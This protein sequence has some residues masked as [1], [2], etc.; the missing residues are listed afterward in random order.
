MKKRFKRS[1]LISSSILLLIQLSASQDIYTIRG[2]VT[3]A[4]NNDYLAAANIRLLGTSKGTITNVQ[5]RYSLSIGA[6]THTL[7]FSYLA[8]QPETLAINLTESVVKD[9]QLKPSPIQLPEF[10]VLAED[11]AIEIIRKAIANKRSWMDKLKS[12]KFDAFSR[13]VIRR[14]TAIASITESYS[15]GYMLI[16]DTLREV[17]KQKRQTE[18]IPGTENFAAV[19]R[20]INFND[21]EIKLFNVGVN[22]KST[23]FTFVGPTAPDALDYYDYKLMG[24]SVVNGFE[25]YKIRMIPKSRL[26]PL[27]DGIITIAEGTYAVMG[28]DVKPNETFTFPFVKDIDLRY[29][30]QFGLFDSLFWMPIDNRISGGLSVSIVGITMPR[31]GIEATSSIYDYKINITIPDTVLKKPRL[32]VDSSSIKFDSTFWAQNEVLPLTADEQK[33]YK[34]LDSTQTLDKQFKPSGP[35]MALSDD[36]VG[37]ILNYLDVRFN[38]VEGFFFGGRY[39]MDTVTN[40]LSL[41]GSGGYGF[42]DKRF[43]YEV[44]T[45][46]F[47]SKDRKLKAGGSYY[48][49]LDNVP[50][51][52]YFGSFAITLM[53]LIDKNDYRDYFLT[54]GWNA[55]IEYEPRR[56]LS[57]TISFLNEK[58]SSMI[59]SVTR[60]LF[61]SQ[62]SFRLNP[63]IAEGN[64]RSLQFDFRFGDSPAPLDLVPRDAI[65]LRIEH[66]SS[67]LLK[68]DFNFTRYRVDVDFN[69]PTYAQS[70]LFPPSLKFRVSGGISNGTLPQQRLFVL[71]SRASG[72]APFGVLRGSGI[73]EFRG[74]RF[75]KFNI[76]HNFRSTPFLA[77]DI[78]YFYRN[79]IEIILHGSFAQTWLANATTS[80]GW[81]SEMGIGVSK[82]FDI[83]RAD[84]TYRMKEPKQFYFTLS[85]ANIF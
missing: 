15:T 71:D 82:I 80:N 47:L 59:N 42:S 38:R 34:S 7:V 74:D 77:M 81:Y 41:N 52:G 19:H 85:V 27:F 5:G 43:K 22:R 67:K 21:D 65:E 70:L 32:A 28:V 14:D 20:I 51:D 40:F 66:S 33:A 60:G 50:D 56:T 72:V 1:L 69:L 46:I 10:L 63:P 78:P 36:G 25:I 37:G 73:K 57:G 45:T 2:I 83:L 68:S 76:E 35:L 9:I 30:Q 8:Y 49:K 64:F 18:N 16:G 61:S 62:K 17:V 12:Y 3:D 23:S 4:S 79:G 54:K 39:E 75:L 31:F 13:Q 26:R 6:G 29:K 84:F 44:G 55:F 48:Y 24:T 11:P 53:S 58:Q